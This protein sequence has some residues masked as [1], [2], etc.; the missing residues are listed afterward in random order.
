MEPLSDHEARADTPL[1]HETA[2]RVAL[3][4]DA[5]VAPLL[6]PETSVSIRN[7]LDG[8]WSRGFT[9][10]EVD[11]QGYRVRRRSDGH[12]LPHAFPHRDVIPDRDRPAG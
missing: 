12:L 6:R 5:H 3:V 1:L 7:S 2:M 8:Q 11:A 4:G 9:V 10:V